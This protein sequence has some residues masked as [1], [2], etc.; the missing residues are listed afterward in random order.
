MKIYTPVN[1]PQKDKQEIESL[2]EEMESL[3]A[4]FK[5]AYDNWGVEF[6]EGT[7]VAEESQKLNRELAQFK[8]EYEELQNATIEYEIKELSEDKIE[9][10]NVK[11]QQLR[12]RMA[13]IRNGE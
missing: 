8:Q 3:Q 2:I 13:A 10:I 11:A 6:L 1:I 9:D 12:R 7:E 5:R 4:D